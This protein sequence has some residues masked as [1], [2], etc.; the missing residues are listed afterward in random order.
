MRKTMSEG[1]RWGF[2][3]LLL[4]LLVVAVC[5]GWLVFWRSRNAKD[6]V[7]ASTVPSLDV[8]SSSFVEGGRIPPK[9]TCDG[10]DVSPQLSVSAPPAGTK[11]LAWLVN[12]P[13]SP[14]D[15][16][17]WV[18]FNLP[19][20]LRDL[21]EGAS[22]QPANLHGTV[23]DSNDFDKT[24]YGGP[25]PPGQKPHHYFFRV[26]ALDNS[27]QLGAGATRTDVAQAAKSHVLAEG[28]IVGLYTR[29]K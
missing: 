9:F 17:H 3:L 10:G 22:A 14:V 11:T 1:R 13:D 18:I 4:V 5:A 23:Q 16:V 25:C 24:G 15:F 19:A 7:D 12:D 26:Y 27:L 6:I 8:T 28:K 21:P 20:A 29:E 2:G